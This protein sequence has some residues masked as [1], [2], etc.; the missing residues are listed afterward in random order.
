MRQYIFIILTATIFLLTT[1]T[2]SFSQESVFVINNIIVSGK[3]DVNFTREKYIDLA[4]KSSF[5]K[6]MSKILTTKD[7]YRLGNVKI[8]KIKKL[9]NNFQVLDEIYIKNKYQLSLKVF[10]DDEKIKQFLVEKNIS[11]SETKSI[12]AVLFPIL[13]INGEMKNFNNNYFYNQW[14][15]V[16]IN[17]ELINFLLPLDDLD[18][19]SLI[20]KMK[21][22]TEDINISKITN[23]YNSNNYAFLFMDYDNKKLNVH[24][25]T[26]FEDNKISKNFFYKI[27]DIKNNKKLDSILKELKIEITDIWKQSNLINLS[28]PLSIRLKFKHKTLNELDK[29]KK[30]FYNVSIINKYTLE[31]L[32][33]KNSY[34]KIYYYGNPKK[35]KTE[36]KKFGYTLKEDSGQ[37]ELYING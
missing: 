37:W 10:Y 16:E 22:K 35:L 28:I 18:D 32:N 14:N 33:I 8:N 11:F 19:L 3:V 5:K 4:F 31:E 27:D 21:N 9:I 24:I 17:S 7:L 6:L 13:V 20:N 29:L 12:S 34:F 1:F 25:K 36:F 2:K 30:V 23:K 15:K 26:N